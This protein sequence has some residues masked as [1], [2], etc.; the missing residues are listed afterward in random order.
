MHA[1]VQGAPGAPPG[2]ERA[3]SARWG[4]TLAVEDAASPQAELSS[5]TTAL[6]EL[7]GR[8]TRLAERSAGT[9]LDWLTG[10]LYEGE[11]ALGEARRRLNRSVERL[12][13]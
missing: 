1:T 6:D 2:I 9:E 12:R 8:V 10:D 11:R 3:R 7:A 4:K 13:R 5:I